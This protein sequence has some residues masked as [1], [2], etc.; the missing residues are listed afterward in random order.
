MTY[1]KVIHSQLKSNYHH[2]NYRHSII[3]CINPLNGLD[4]GIPLNLFSNVYT[5]LHYGYDI[6][7][8][9]SVLMQFLLGY[10]TY[11]KDRYSDAMEY[12][13]NPYEIEEKKE[14][15]YKFLY[16]YKDFYNLTLNFTLI[17]IIFSLINEKNITNILLN[18]PFIPI[19]YINGF[20]KYFKQNLYIYKS[21]YISIMW[22][23][24]TIII[25]C[26]LHDHSYIILN[27]PNDYLPCLLT[28]FATSNFADSKDIK[29]DKI[30]KINTI[31]VKY[32]LELSNIISFIA[33]II[34]S[35]LLIENYNFENRIIINS[36]V[37]LQ[38]IGIMYL[39]YN[40]TYCIK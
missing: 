18:L 1:I 20:Y 29:E 22:T 11:G 3:T 34:S 25:P 7:T 6:T 5:N 15:L 39:L 36:I 13:S 24:A 40:N 16:D 28:L 14:E 26:V 30:N 21:L 2:T 33:I 4:V 31:P 23:I 37:E 27:Y 10:Y 8:Y 17:I 32:G 35:I 38:N 9:K 12:I 19:F